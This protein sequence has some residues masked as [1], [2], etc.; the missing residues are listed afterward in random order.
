MSRP[1]LITIP[2]GAGVGGNNPGVQIPLQ[3]QKSVT[4]INLNQTTSIN[5]CI[6]DTFSPG[7]TWPLGGGNAIPQT[8]IDNLWAQN[9]G[10]EDVELL[11][12][13]GIVPV[14]LYYPAGVP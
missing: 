2:S 3:G 5:L 4:L 1:Q 9:T 6:G 12:L 13:S 7:T 11:I 8:D 10:N 14:S